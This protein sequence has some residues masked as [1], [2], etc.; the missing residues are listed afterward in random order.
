MLSKGYQCIFKT[1]NDG[2]AHLLTCKE[3]HKTVFHTKV[4]VSMLIVNPFF[5]NMDMERKT[6]ELIFLGDGTNSNFYFLLGF[7]VLQ[8]SITNI[9]VLCN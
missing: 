9:Q 5:V 7:Y 4:Y 3:V 6:S 8:F 1:L 2:I